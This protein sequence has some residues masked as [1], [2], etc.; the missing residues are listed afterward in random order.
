[1]LVSNDKINRLSSTAIFSELDTY[2]LKELLPEFEWIRLSGGDTLFREGDSGEALYVVL[3]GRLR[4]SIQRGDGLEDIVGDVALGECVGE[5][6]ILTGEPRSATVRAVRDTDLAKLSSS[7]VNR[8]LERNPQTVMRLARL[9][10]KR[11]RQAL[12]S[13]T[14]ERSPVCTIA[15]L[16]AD[17]SALART[18]VDRLVQ[19][20]QCA[21]STAH[22]NYET[23]IGRF[24][25][26]ADGNEA[27]DD[28]II[29]WLND[30]E[31]SHRFV[32]YEADTDAIWWTQLCLRQADRILTVVPSGTDIWR[33]Q[34]KIKN[35]LPSH[36]TM[37]RN[38]LIV[39]HSSSN[40]AIVGTIR[41][42]SDFHF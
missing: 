36:G 34:F 27:I 31:L 9:I 3:S 29:A 4:A 22:L 13:T 20:L 40:R 6:A 18:F 39:L 32:I 25:L 17:P 5:L 16:R 33:L 38:E 41:L 30:V 14:N 24:G 11:Q 37:P 23:I 12:Y 7:S 21:G 2:S 10:A 26:K 1:M 15:I 8:L 19:T 28:R 35:L 42:L